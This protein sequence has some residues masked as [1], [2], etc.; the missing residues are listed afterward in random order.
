M[1]LQDSTSKLYKVL[2]ILN[3]D[4]ANSDNLRQTTEKDYGSHIT[5]KDSG[6]PSPFR[7][8]RWRP[9]PYFHLEGMVNSKINFLW[10]LQTQW[11]NHH[12]PTLPKMYGKGCNLHHR[13]TR[14]RENWCDSVSH[15]WNIC[16]GSQNLQEGATDPVSVTYEKDLVLARWTKLTH[17]KTALKLAKKIILE[18]MVNL[19]T[20]FEL[21]SHNPDLNFQDFFLWGCLKDQV[22]AGNPWP[23]LNSRK[24]SERR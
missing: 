1:S 23:S 12:V 20:D 15:Q 16:W 3:I 14:L 22:Y 2:L 21:V 5:W 19:K 17:L 11:S 13:T 7:G 6:D 18:A 10:D 8:L 24:P 9:L 4:E